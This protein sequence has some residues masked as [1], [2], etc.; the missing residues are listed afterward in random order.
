MKRFIVLVLCTAVF[1]IGL[2]NLVEQAGATLK[3]D[4][5]ALEI[6][7]KA[8]RAIGGDSAIGG[9]KSMTITGKATK[10]FEVEGVARSEQGDL[11]INFE[12]PNKLSRTMKLGTGEGDA[13]AEKKV[14]V[15]VMRTGG[16][17]DNMRFKVEDG[18]NPDG[19]RKIIVKKADG[20]TEELKSDGKEPVIIKKG[21]AEVVTTEDGKTATVD[22]KKVFIRRA[23]TLAGGGEFQRSNE[24][25]RTTL[26]L[27]LTAPEGLE[28]SYSYAGEGSVDGASCDIIAANDGGSTIRLYLDKSTSLP[29]MMTFQAHKPF[30]LKVEKTDA[31]PGASG[32]FKIM[33]RKLPE[34][35]MAEFQVKFSDFRA[36]NGLQLP[37]KW[38]QTVAGKDDEVIDVASYDVNP[39]NIA[40]KFKEMPAPGKIFLRTKKEQ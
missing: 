4:E 38:T 22:G 11:E 2:G 1:F 7:G 32:D 30:M 3:S 34:P 23:D 13:L 28:V 40:D 6:I 26:S 25:F 31:T 21:S 18:S 17:G 15:I 10:T 24:L 37:F 14:D 33:T 20:S 8:R 36:V 27:L 35:E 9:V 5:K 29:R 19:V 16:E 12:L 39:A